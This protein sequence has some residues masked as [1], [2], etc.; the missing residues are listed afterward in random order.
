MGANDEE[1]AKGG[2]IF[3][4]LSGKGQATK[5]TGKD[6]SLSQ[7][8]NSILG[9]GYNYIAHIKTPG[10]LGMSDDGN[11]GALENDIGGILSYMDL[12][13]SGHGEFGVAGKAILPGGQFTDYKGPLGNNF[14]LKT[15]MECQPI[16][17]G[18]KTHRYIY[19][20]NVP[21][22]QIPLISSIDSK[23]KF[24]MF[25]GLLPGVLSKLA[26]IHPMQ[27]LSAF[28]TGSSP[29]CQMV[30]MPVVDENNQHSF[31]HHYITNDDISIMP[32]DW[33]PQVAGQ[34]QSDYNLDDGFCTMHDQTAKLKSN[35][36][37]SAER[38]YSKMPNDVLIKFYYSMLGL[39]GIYILLKM[40]MKKKI[41]G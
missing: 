11:F 28:T 7:T 6:S 17:G 5:G 35:G 15:A 26:Q 32:E 12:L 24:T 31:D 1:D 13:V 23:L 4:R 40:M 41:K 30:T 34:R 36:G 22:G 25:E 19:V 21:D 2:D 27:T 39:L 14:F 38:D 9:P 16:E 20:N 3:S 29:T 33:F 8:E 37:G 10:N 18:K